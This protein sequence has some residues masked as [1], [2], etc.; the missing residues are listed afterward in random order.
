M[1]SDQEF[2]AD[3][4]PSVLGE[5]PRPL[6]DSIIHVTLS[7]FQLKAASEGMKLSAR[8]RAMLGAGAEVAVGLTW[9][10]ITKRAE[11]ELCIC[12]PGTPNYAGPLEDCEVH[13]SGTVVCPD[14]PDG[15]H[16]DVSATDGDGLVLGYSHCGYCGYVA[17]DNQS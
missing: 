16:H 17:E 7:A 14:S 3:G 9:E 12:A 10:A 5:P 13:G 15:L 6:V 8:D 11:R 1:P 4:T 2:V